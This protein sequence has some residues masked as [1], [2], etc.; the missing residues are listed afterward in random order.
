MLNEAKLAKDPLTY[1]TKEESKTLEALVQKSDSVVS[2]DEIAQAIWGQNWLK[3]YSDWQIDRLIYLVRRK[4]SSAYTI[5]TIRNRGYVFISNKSTIPHIPTPRVEGTTPTQSYLEYMN[6]PQNPRKVLFDLF[7]AAK[8]EQI[9]PKIKKTKLILVVNSFSADNV[10]AAAKVFPGSEVYFSNFDSRALALHQNQIDKLSL[11]LFHT[12]YDDLRHS[13]LAD[14]TFDLIINDFRLNFNT[15]HL[16]NQLATG[17]IFRLLKTKGQVIISVVIDPRHKALRFYQPWTFQA[18]EGLTRF[19][20]TTVYY[21][22]LFQDCSFKI[23]ADFDQKNGRLWR[24][25]YRRFLL[26]K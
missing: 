9:L 13:R 15:T 14:S 18:Q 16:Q 19:C 10:E 24:P 20:F 22:K 5:K 1:F 23:V 17:N 8:R 11:P 2:R 21:Q 6:N 7:S 3:R 4:L 12:T 26:Q 25:S